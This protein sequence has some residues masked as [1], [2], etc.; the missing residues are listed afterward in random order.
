MTMMWTQARGWHGAA[1]ALLAIA[2]ERL[3]S[4]QPA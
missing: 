4:R 1:E 2:M 3:K